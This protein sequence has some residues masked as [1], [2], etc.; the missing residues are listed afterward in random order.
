MRLPFPLVAFAI[1]GTATTAVAS[2]DDAWKEFAA[3]VEQKCLAAAGDML[4]APEAV[5][6]P[7][8]SARFGLAIVTGKAKG[9]DTMASHICVLDK[10][11]ETVEIG[12][13]LSAEQVRIK[14]DK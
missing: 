9:T 1:L 7:F 11:S 14:A 5:V 3:T 13:E 2:S 4:D 10:Q 12:S 8:G 6:D